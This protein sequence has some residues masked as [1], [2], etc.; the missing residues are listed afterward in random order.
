LVQNGFVEI[1][2]GRES[3]IQWLYVSTAYFVCTLIDYLLNLYP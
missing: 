1:K 3:I 2:I